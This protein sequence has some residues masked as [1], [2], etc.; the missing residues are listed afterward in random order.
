MLLMMLMLLLLRLLVLLVLLML[1]VLLVQLQLRTGSRLSGGIPAVRETSPVVGILAVAVSMTVHLLLLHLGHGVERGERRRQHGCVRVPAVLQVQEAQ[2]A[3]LCGELEHLGD[4]RRRRDGHLGPVTG[5][6]AVLGHGCWRRRGG[7]LVRTRA[8][9]R[10]LLRCACSP[11]AGPLFAREGTCHVTASSLLPTARLRN[12]ATTRLRDYAN[13]RI[14]DATCIA[15]TT[16]TEHGY[17]R[18]H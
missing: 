3:L 14:R 10:L 8:A 7:C 18:T 12:Y 17:L 11:A 9:S 15:R 5:S 1:L 13:T 2:L 16:Y 6:V 4:G